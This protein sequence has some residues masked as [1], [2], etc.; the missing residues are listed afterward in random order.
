MESS[1]L[2]GLVE[3]YLNTLLPKNWYRMDLE[4]RRCFLRN[5]A[6]WRFE[7]GTS[8]EVQDECPQKLQGKCNALTPC[9]GQTCVGTE[10]RTKVCRSEIWCE[11]FGKAQEDLKNP[12][13]REITSIMTRIGGWKQM[14][15]KKHFPPYGSQYYYVRTDSTEDGNGTGN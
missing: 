11:C 2:D 6:E 15:E 3:E 14:P 7:N 5:S 12:N 4:S 1:D 9:Q 10:V 13:S 8:C